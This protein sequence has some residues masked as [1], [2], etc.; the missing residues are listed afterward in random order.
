MSSLYCPN[1]NSVWCGDKQ[2]AI[3]FSGAFIVFAASLVTH[4]AFGLYFFVKWLAAWMMGQPL[5]LQPS[6]RTL[7][8]EETPIAP[9]RYTMMTWLYWLVRIFQLCVYGT[10]I[11][12]L[13]WAAFRCVFDS[14]DALGDPTPISRDDAVFHASAASA[15]IFA[16]SVMLAVGAYFL[17]RPLFQFQ[18]YFTI[19]WWMRALL[20]LFVLALWAGYFAGWGY[21]TWLL[22]H[23]RSPGRQLFSALATAVTGLAFWSL[24]KAHEDGHKI[25]NVET[26]LI[27]LQSTITERCVYFL[28]LMAVACSLSLHA[29]SSTQDFSDVQIAVFVLAVALPIGIAL[30][31]KESIRAWYQMAPYHYATLIAGQPEEDARS[32][33]ALTAHEWLVLHEQSIGAGSFQRTASDEEELEP[34][35]TASSVFQRICATVGSDSSNSMLSRRPTASAVPQR[36]QLGSRMWS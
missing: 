34:Q 12:L 17:N 36:A 8:R 9:L 18:I 15:I 25:S 4:V 22:A 24:V 1:V 10:G 35:R 11:A 2:S 28:A 20:V 14:D 7:P 33:Y 21:F 23:H 5:A 31:L 29:L 13:G 26:W 16:F 32:P 19:R 6:D 27:T 3:A 30:F